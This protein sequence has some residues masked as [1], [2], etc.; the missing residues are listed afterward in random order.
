M[1]QRAPLV[2]IGLDAAEISLIDDLCAHGQMPALRALRE[3]GCSGSLSGDVNRFPGSVWPDFY[4]SKTV[5]WHGIYHGRQW[6]QESMRCET[7]TRERFPTAPF[8]E[9][10]DPNR[11]RVAVVD[12]P[13]VVGAPRPLNGIQ[14]EG[15]GTHD[16]LVRGSWPTSLW[17]GVEREF[18]RPRM[19]LEKFGPHSAPDLLRLHP[20]LVGATQQ[21]GT[22][23]STLLGREAW[24]LFLVVFGAPHHSGHYFWNLTQTD[25]A[26]LPAERLRRLEGAVGEVYRA[27]DDAIARIVD[28]APPNARMMVFALHGMDRTPGGAD[29]CADMLACIQGQQ[30]GPIS[31][32]RVVSG[33]DRL[34]PRSLIRPITNRLPQR[35]QDGLLTRW[36]GGMLDRRS[37]RA[38]PLLMDYAGYVRINLQ[39]REP[40][41]IV[42]PGQ[43]YQALCRDLADAFLSFRDIQTGERIVDR[44]Y[45]LDEIAPP[46]APY[47]GALPDLVITWADRSSIDSV[48]VRSA[49]FGE[50][51]WEP[52][53]RLPSG[54]AGDHSHRGWFVAAGEG[55]PASTHADGHG[56][57]DLAP[58]VFNWLGAEQPADFQGRPIPALCG[59]PPG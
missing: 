13:M 8:W 7:P 56:L 27:C 42:A 4:T 47:R 57:S 34:L 5:P 40:R 21:M 49:Q 14:L 16:L 32:A 23:S 15:W 2:L 52:P 31:S 45:H 19:P 22:I 29:R 51:R 12:V 6:W 10:L 24:D 33:L 50:I 37:T 28:R 25:L 58:T 3:R 30:G 36:S 38:F 20:D 11:Y 17:R 53:G 54:R 55:I 44:V 9:R 43:E 39:G 26:G 46:E 48:G 1:T 18:G 35:L 59:L 41:G